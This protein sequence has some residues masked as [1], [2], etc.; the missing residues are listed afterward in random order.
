MRIIRLLLLTCI[1]IYNTR[2]N[3]YI[4]AVSTVLTHSTFAHC[5]LQPGDIINFFIVPYR[6]GL[7]Y[8]TAEP[9]S[10]LYAFKVG[11]F[12]EPIQKNLY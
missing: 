3:E 6:T 10:N 8:W 1:Y 5:S 4:S 2:H 7:P 9:T 12:T 11:E